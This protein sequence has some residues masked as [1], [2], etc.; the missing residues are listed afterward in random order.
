MARWWGA[1][2]TF[3]PAYGVNIRECPYSSGRTGLLD[4]ER[5]RRLRPPPLSREN[6]NAREL[7]LFR[8]PSDSWKPDGFLSSIIPQTGG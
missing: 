1:M 6:S 2:L 8:A 3:V 4:K 5:E 7:R